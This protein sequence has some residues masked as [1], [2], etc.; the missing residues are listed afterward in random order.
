MNSKEV[1]RNRAEKT[2]GRVNAR[3][4]NWGGR[5]QTTQDLVIH[6]KDFEQSPKSFRS[7]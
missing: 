1:R 6:Y 7:Y 3:R 5:R 4:G 2:K